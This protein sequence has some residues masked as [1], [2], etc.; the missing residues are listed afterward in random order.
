MTLP[1]EE[2]QAGP[3][4]G[5]PE[6]GT[7]ID[8]SSMCATAPEDPTVGQDMHVKTVILTIP[9]PCKPRTMTMCVFVFVLTTMFK[10]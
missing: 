9:T 6:G 1:Q 2:I 10:K 5:V 4:E 7:V 3:Q 8:D